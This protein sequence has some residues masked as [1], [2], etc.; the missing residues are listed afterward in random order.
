M[1]QQHHKAAHAQPLA[2]AGGDELVDDDLGAVGEIA[3]L[4]LPQHEGFG[5]GDGI[6][7]LEAEHRDFGEGAVDD[8]ELGLVLAQMIQRDVALLR[9]LVDEH[10]VA[11]GKRAAAGILAGKPHPRALDKQGPEGKRL[12]RRPVD[13]L[14]ALDHPALGVEQAQ[15][16]AMHVEIL[17]RPGQRQPDFLEN[18]DAR[19]RI[20]PADVARGHLEA[21]P[22]A[23]Q[24]V[25]LVG[26][27][28][29]GSLEILLQAAAEVAPDAIGLLRGHYPL[30]DKP[31][32]IDLLGRR[33]A[34]DLAVHQW[35]GEGGLVG[36]VVAVA[37]IT[38][39]VDDDVLLEGLPVLDG[40][41]GDVDHRLGVVAVDVE[42][43]RL[44]HLRDVRGIGRGA[45]VAGRCGKADLV[46]DDEVD[47]AAGSVA[48]QAR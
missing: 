20:A 24:P 3:E 2:L 40:E 12:G 33:V 38:E 31:A 48:A 28:G 37:A 15:D 45:K 4:R 22:G 41:P 5:V 32:R 1:G 9:L 29:F 36:F 27:V 14:A 42:D 8:L 23:F 26:L 19:H 46:V 30:A 17:G 18:L 47:G 11:L 44:D 13:A 25:G 34:G 7:V 21:G 16:A 35:L 43:R 39:Q 6:P 10:G